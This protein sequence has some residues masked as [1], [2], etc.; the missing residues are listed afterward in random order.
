MDRSQPKLS[1]RKPF[2]QD[3]RRTAGSFLNLFWKNDKRRWDLG[4]AAGHWSFLDSRQQ[5]PRHIV[6]ADMMRA[7]GSSAANLLDVGC[8]TGALVP[9][10]PENVARYVGI[11]L[12]AEAI[13]VC[14]AKHRGSPKRSFVATPFLDY[15]DTIPFDVVVFN[16][17]LYYYPLRRIPAVLDH[18]RTLLGSRGGVVIVS[19]HDRCPK[20][21]GVWK[22]VN[23]CVTSTERAQACDPESGRS[24]RIELYE[25]GPAH[26]MGP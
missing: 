3:V 7:R 23:R 24:W 8:G 25:V 21:R 20:K 26:D 16:E 12:S 1:G 13:H 15:A 9:H 2:A 22:T 4:Y 14:S 18:A 5:S 17:M 19:V 11:D 6:I 10:L